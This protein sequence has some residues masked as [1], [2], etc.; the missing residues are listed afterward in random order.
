MTVTC[1][2]TGGAL[3]PNLCN[4]NKGRAGVYRYKRPDGTFKTI[5][6]PYAQACALA[7][8]A[9]KLRA[10]STAPSGTLRFWVDR[11]ILWSEAQNPALAGK[12]GW[13]NRR[14]ALLKFSDDWQHVPIAKHGVHTFAEWWHGLSYDQQHNRRSLFSQFYQWAMSQGATRVNPF[15]KSDTEAHLIE[16]KKPAKQRLPLEIGDFWRVHAV[17]PAHV[18]TAMLISLTTTM[19]A[20]DVVALRFDDIVD[21]YLRRTI[22]KSVGQRG[23][24]AASHLKW[25]LE[26]HPTLREAINAARE[27][28]LKHMRCP[29]IVS[30]PVV[31]RRLRDG[32]THPN[33]CA[34][35]HISK[36]FSAAVQA[37]GLFSVL[38]KGRTPPTFH[39]V[40]GLAIERLLAAGVDIRNVQTL[41][42]HTDPSITSAY[43][44]GHTPNYLDAGVVMTA[45]M[46]ARK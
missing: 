45:E 39:E 17:A 8:K 31:T 15:N 5:R 28:S 25:Q 13:R 12:N 2:Q 7:V 20:G 3:P 10:E 37:A 46:I 41:A 1:K 38:P 21:G 19:R 23:Q 18:R 44:A 4:D 14:Q 16:K 36:G 24:M 29:Y 11:F 26:Q 40:R 32:L 42:A 9:N 30:R 22:S 34:V 27:E 43:A 35:E 6:A 33:Q